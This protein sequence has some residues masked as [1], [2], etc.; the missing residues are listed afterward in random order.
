MH[1]NTF[2]T[3]ALLAFGLILVSFVLM[4]FSRI[5][6]PFRVA[7]LLAAPTITV[8]ALLVAYLFIES[9]LVTLGVRE[10]EE[11]E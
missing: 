11:P 6:L 8:G 4:G 5:V 2:A 3:L 7:R 1:R 10:L 9:V